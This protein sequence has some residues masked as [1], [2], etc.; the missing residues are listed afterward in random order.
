MLKTIWQLMGSRER[1]RFVFLMFGIVLSSFWNIGG[2]ASIMPFMQSLS[3]PDRVI[4]II[5]VQ[6]IMDFTGI[7]SAQGFLMLSGFVVLFLFVTGNI[8]LALVT[9]RTITFTRAVGYS[10]STR[11]FETYIQQPYTFYLNR[12]SSELTKNLLGETGNVTSNIVK[13]TMEII[14]Q[15]VLSVAIVAFLVL[16]D[17]IVALS[18]TTLLGGSYALIFVVF[19]R[20]LSRAGRQRVKRNKERFSLSADA[21]GAIKELKLRGLEHRYIERFA[22]IANRF[23]QSKAR[24]QTISRLPKYALDTIAFGGILAIAL[25]VFARQRGTDM[26]IPLVSTYAFAGYRL[27]PSLQKFFSAVTLLRGN[28][29]SLKVVQKELTLSVEAPAREN[30]QRLPFKK[31]FRI[32]GLTFAYPNSSQP[33]LRDIEMRVRKNTTVGIAGPTGCGKTTLIDIVLGLLRSRE[34]NVFADE[35]A[36]DNTN[37]QLWQQN[38]GYVPQSIYLSDTSVRKNIAFGVRDEEIDDNRVTFAAKLA[39]LHDFVLTMNEGYE[40]E[41]GERGVRMSG[42]Q[43]QRV[44]IARA[45]YH[46]PDI[47]VFDEAT[48]ALDTHTEQA[49]M[50]A[51]TNI[52]HTKTILIIAHRLSTLRDCDEIYVLQ[53]GAIDAVGTYEELKRSHPHFT[54]QL[55]E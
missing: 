50:D 25:V 38:F 52:M 23:E 9:W 6:Q 37:I 55:E 16:V 20:V 14:V 35:T 44:G 28:Q 5:L 2:I 10:L 11:L 48:S 53:A 47:L 4:Q 24:V 29:A 51:I 12:N 27:M 15:G 30:T 22:V 26:I 32:E 21:F 34:G 41:L 43:R 42:G 18:A 3:A 1:R 45:L 49:V 54:R 19:R 39:N 8:L 7:E 31:E 36:I 46:D 33:V 13:P 17:P 40:T